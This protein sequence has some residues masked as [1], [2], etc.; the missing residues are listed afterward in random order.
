MIDALAYDK[1]QNLPIHLGIERKQ[2]DILNRANIILIKRNSKA[3]EHK[4]GSR[5][6]FS[7]IVTQNSNRSIWLL[8][9]L[10]SL[11]P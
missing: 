6:V 8:S 4:G 7:P 2:W 10:S 1:V 9:T 11:Q 5:M 3:N